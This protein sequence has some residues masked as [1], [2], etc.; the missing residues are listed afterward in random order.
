MKRVIIPILLIINILSLNAQKDVPLKR[1]YLG[2]D[3]HV[4]LMYNGTEEKWSQLILDMADF[5]LNLG[6]GSKN[7]EPAK[8]SKWNYDCAYWLWVLEHKTPPQYFDRIIAQIK[9]QQASVPY[10]FTLPIYGASTTE[11]VLRSFYYSG[12]LERKYGIDVD[13]AVCQ[14]NA[15]IPLGLTSLF[16]GAGAKYSWKGVCNC[17]TK[18]L[19]KGARKHEIYWNKGLDSSKI[20]MKW[21]SNSGW[22]AELGGY[23]EMLEPTVAVIQMDTLCGTSRYP[24]RIAGAFGR[25]WDNMVNYAYD[26]QWGVNHRTRPC[27]KVFISNE[28]DFFNDFEKNYGDVL[29]SQTAAYGNE[30]D[31][32]PASFMTVSGGIRR[33][34]EKL[35]S[36]ESMAAIVASQNPKAFD[37]LKDMKK[38]A[39][40]AISVIS[41]HGWTIDGPIKKKQFAD[42]AR[43]QLSRIETYTNT[44]FTESQKILRGMVKVEQGKKQYMVF[45]PLSW[46]RTDVADLPLENNEHIEI[47]DPVL[48][49]KINHQIIEKEGKKY[50]R[51]VAEKLPSVGYKTF[52]IKE[53]KGVLTKKA[54]ESRVFIFKNNMLETPF[55]KVKFA[56]SGAILSL[57][58]KRNLKEYAKNIG[59]KYLNS[60]SDNTLTPNRDEAESLKGIIA[61]QNA[62]N[63]SI[64][65]KAE[66]EKPL[67]FATHITFYNN[68]A[69]IDFDNEIRDTIANPTYWTYSFNVEKPTIWHEEVGAVVKAKYEKEGGHYADEMSRTDHLSLNHFADVSN[70]QGGI[71]LSDLDCLF[72]KIGDSEPQK[73]DSNSPQINVLAGGQI[74]ANY[75][76][77]IIKQ[78]G[79]T[80]FSQHFSIMP[81]VTAYNQTA[82]MKFSLEHQ[83]PLII[84]TLENTNGNLP[85]QYS[86]L[87]TD[88]VD[89]LLWSLKP[90]EEEGAGIAAR[91]WNMSNQPTEAT[92]IFDKNIQKAQEATHVETP[93]MAKIPLSNTLK[94]KA[95]QQQMRTFL[96]K[97]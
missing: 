32:L 91:I 51:F 12:Y 55:Y 25:G 93:L 16:N 18:T 72:M 69:R 37:H 83:N 65:I 58:D 31:L 26:V 82:A 38:D 94:I 29:P 78:D 56:N 57:V 42:W 88:N 7:E 40:Y 97:F 79:D 86:F 39:F 49:K 74:D 60:L 34:M 41:A 71:T 87:K 63:Q 30:W 81:H 45:N 1:L 28:L 89:V 48:K 2:N 66:G 59:G 36:A 50:A 52:E 5:Y 35:R 44:L 92:L 8:R 90:A 75:N 33:A 27:T 76:L 96:V 10:N 85:P 14:E 46:E 21:Y 62:G 61:A 47:F 67:K 6:E 11:S 77:G 22:N 70:A 19:T 84:N 24:Y 9:N 4:D 23:A 54:N 80:Y 43:L 73:L 13:I 3:T 53:N 20:L 15:T 95:Q 17:A 64:T 68:S